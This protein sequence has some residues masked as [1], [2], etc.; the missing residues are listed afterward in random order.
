MSL[1]RLEQAIYSYWE[2]QPDE[3]RHWEAK[4]MEIAKARSAPGEAARC[5]DRDLWAYFVERSGQVRELSALGGDLR[6]TSM[7]NLAELMLRLWGPLPKPK[8]SAAPPQ[9]G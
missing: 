5:L 8:K 9:R 2:R 3:R 7:L 6:R 4:T 1:N